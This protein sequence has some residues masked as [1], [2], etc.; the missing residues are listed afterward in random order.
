MIQ[1]H[2]LRLLL[3]TLTHIPF[4]NLHKKLLVVCGI[5]PEFCQPEPKDGLHTLVSVKERLITVLHILGKIG[6]FWVHNWIYWALLTARDFS[7]HVKKVGF[8]V[9]LLDCD[10]QQYS[11]VGFNLQLLWTNLSWCQAPILVPRRKLYHYQTV[12]G[13]LIWGALSDERMGL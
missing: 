1:E 12:A 10:F 6:T 13:L 7:L 2:T 11:V 4:R 5:A 9:T 3:R 8:S